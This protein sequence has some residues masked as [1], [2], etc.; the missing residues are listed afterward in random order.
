MASIIIYEMLSEINKKFKQF[1]RNIV[2]NYKCMKRLSV[3]LVTKEIQIKI[4]H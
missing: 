3:S 2:N 1:I 4:I